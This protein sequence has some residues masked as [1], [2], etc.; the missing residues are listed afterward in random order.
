VLASWH[1]RHAVQSLVH[2]SSPSGGL[3]E[4]AAKV[5]VGA[6]QCES[7]AKEVGE[8]GGEGGGPISR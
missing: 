2:S 3:N 7:G 1:A 4:R 5:V 6:G 8:G